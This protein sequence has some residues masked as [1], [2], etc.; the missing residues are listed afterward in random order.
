[1]LNIIEAIVHGLTPGAQIILALCVFMAILLTAT[2]RDAVRNFCELLAAITQLIIGVR[3][4]K[5]PKQLP[6]KAPEEPPSQDAA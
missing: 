3:G 5:A 2:S 4:S 1:M 6:E